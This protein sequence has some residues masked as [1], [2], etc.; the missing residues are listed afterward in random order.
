MKLF[1]L[2]MLSFSILLLS[3]GIQIKPAHEKASSFTTT[4][5]LNQNTLHVPKKIRS[6]FNS[7]RTTNETDVYLLAMGANTGK[8]T[9]ANQDAQRFKTAIQHRYHIPESNIC[10]LKDV[11]RQEVKQAIT[12]LHQ[13]SKKNDLIILYFS[14]HGTQIVD[15]DRDELPD[16]FDE[17]L[18]TY[19]PQRPSPSGMIEANGVID[20]ELVAWIDALPTKRVLTVLDTCFSGGMYLNEHNLETELARGKSLF[21]PDILKLKGSRAVS[22]SNHP[23]VHRDRISSKQIK[24]LLLSAAEEDQEAIELPK[25][26]GQFTV[27]F[28]RELQK[29]PKNSLQEIFNATA[30]AVARSKHAHH[31]TST[32]D[33]A[34]LSGLDP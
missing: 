7:P 27:L 8:L 28:L 3:C 16:K 9:G 15:N 31:P 19:T 24:G 29:K 5:R 14:G 2:L 13:V 30:R 21:N 25:E 10:L 17:V 1:H 6:C 23:S 33:W 32:G 34:I 18:V 12:R 22:K 11:Y 20:D 26:G 4:F